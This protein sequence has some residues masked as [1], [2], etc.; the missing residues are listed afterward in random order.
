MFA[1]EVGSLSLY[2]FAD[3]GLHVLD[4]RPRGRRPEAFTEFQKLLGPVVEA[5]GLEPQQFAVQTGALQYLVRAAKRPSRGPRLLLQSMT[6]A[7]VAAVND[8]RIDE[9][10]RFLATIPGVRTV[11]TPGAANLKEAAP[12]VPMDSRPIRASMREGSSRRATSQ[13]R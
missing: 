8:K 11:T 13:A 6:L 12:G 4:I 7:P 10:H 2:V 9:P 1:L 3:G 5:L